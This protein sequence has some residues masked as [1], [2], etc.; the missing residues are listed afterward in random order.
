MKVSF[1]SVFPGFTGKRNGMSIYFNSHLNQFIGRRTVKPKFVPCG[2]FMRDV[3]EFR[4]RIEISEGFIQDCRDYVKAY[5]SKHK[6]QNRAMN[7]WTNVY[8]KLMRAFALDFPEAEISSLSRVEIWEKDYPIKSVEEAVQAGYLER[9]R[10][11][12]E[13]TQSV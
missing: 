7:A 13:M 2:D 6:R 9:V 4:D 12:D 5:N 11:W 8:L 1:N 3:F 10:G